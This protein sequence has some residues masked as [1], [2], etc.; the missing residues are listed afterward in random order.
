MVAK[1]ITEDEKLIIDTLNSNFTAVKVHQGEYVFAE[2]VKLL[3]KNVTSFTKRYTPQEHPRIMQ[4]FKTRAKRQVI[5][6]TFTGMLPKGKGKGKG[7]TS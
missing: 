4:Y 5:I 1:Q 2:L 6:T 3:A 7:M